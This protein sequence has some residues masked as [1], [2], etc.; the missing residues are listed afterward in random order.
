MNRESR[1]LRIVLAVLVLTAFTLI[2]LD[3]RAGKGGVLGGGTG[4]SWGVAAV[5]GC[6]Y[7]A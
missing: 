2:T 4:G 7:G 1:R 6:G 3:Y 5:Y